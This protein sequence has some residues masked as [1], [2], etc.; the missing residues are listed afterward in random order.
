[1]SHR[2]ISSDSGVNA[3]KHTCAAT[4]RITD[5]RRILGKS[6]WN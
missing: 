6:V 1:V 3:G 4:C 2:P 5:P